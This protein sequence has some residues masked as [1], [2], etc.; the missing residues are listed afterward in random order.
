M[1]QREKIIQKLSA[2]NEITS[3]W[4]VYNGIFRLSE[5]VRELEQRGWVFSKHFVE[6]DGKKTKTYRYVVLDRPKKVVYDLEFRD[7]VPVR[8]PRY[9]RI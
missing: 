7:G 4:A 5:R 2:D 1:T 9:V 3:V 6:K 8:V